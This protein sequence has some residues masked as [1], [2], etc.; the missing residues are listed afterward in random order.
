V[1]VRLPESR[2]S[3][4]VRNLATWNDGIA[5][6]TVTYADLCYRSSFLRERRMEVVGLPQTTPRRFAFSPAAGAGLSR[7]LWLDVPINNS[8]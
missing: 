2:H 6:Q 8:R 5:D 3:L 4:H 1:A 7:A